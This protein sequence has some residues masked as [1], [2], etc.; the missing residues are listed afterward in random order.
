MAETTG[1]LN[2]KQI[3]ATR[4][5]GEGAQARLIRVAEII[6]WRACSS[7]RQHS[8]QEVPRR[9]TRVRAAGPGS[10]ACERARGLQMLLESYAT[11]LAPVQLGLEKQEMVRQG[12]VHCPPV[13]PLGDM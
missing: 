1:I 4:L 2:R 12:L 9:L 10:A 3:A 11:T 6:T 13:R 8:G 5:S 7:K